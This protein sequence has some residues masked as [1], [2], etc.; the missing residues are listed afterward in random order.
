ML[1]RTGVGVPG[2]E[3][4]FTLRFW[5]EEEWAELGQA[6]LVCHV[7]P[8]GYSKIP[9]EWEVCPVTASWDYDVPQINPFSET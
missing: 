8:Y 1:G 4:L 9:R 7:A 3:S 5:W 6:S 2:E